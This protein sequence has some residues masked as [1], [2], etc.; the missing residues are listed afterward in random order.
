MSFGSAPIAPGERLADH[1]YGQLL[2]Y[3]VEQ[4]LGEGDRL[5]SEHELSRLTAVSRPMVREALMR[6]QGDG[7][8]EARRGAG[9]F[10]RQRPAE[11]QIEHLRPA[12][13]KARLE[14]FAVRIAMESAA[15]ELAA[16]RRSEADLQSIV[17]AARASHT[18]QREGRPG[19]EE[20]FAFHRAIAAASGN[21]R[22][23]S[24]LDFLNVSIDGGMIV[25]SLALVHEESHARADQIQ[26]EHNAIIEA[27]QSG[28]GESA[29]VAM[30][31]HLLRARNRVKAMKWMV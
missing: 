20:D 10:V 28:D 17:A 7:L 4:G 16:M 18:A 23:A 24:C 11:R 26:A 15:A 31:L 30:R 8:I 27:L 25:A 22:F 29:G 19:A 2:E 5:P 9:S 21:A 3:I 14:T 13:M 12:Q 6:L 1:V